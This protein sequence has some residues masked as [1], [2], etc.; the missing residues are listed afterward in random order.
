ML[1]CPLALTTALC[2]HQPFLVP[3]EPALGL[4]ESLNFGEEAIV[5]ARI[6]Q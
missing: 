3:A 5:A 2:Y 6:P 1:N 4:P